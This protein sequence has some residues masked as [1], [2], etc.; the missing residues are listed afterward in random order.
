MEIHAIVS[1]GVAVLISSG[2]YLRFFI[3]SFNELK[4]RQLVANTPTS[5]IRSMAVGLVEIKGKAVPFKNI[6]ESAV[7]RSDCVYYEYL[8]E[9][10]SGGTNPKSNVPAHWTSVKNE[11][12]YKSPF[13]VEDDTGKVLVHPENA[14][15]Y[16]PI[17][18]KMQPFWKNKFQKS[19]VKDFYFRIFKNTDIAKHSGEGKAQS[20]LQTHPEVRT[21]LNAAMMWR[22]TE[23]I[24]RPG[25][26]VY[27]MGTA[28]MKKDSRGHDLN[29]DGLV[30]KMGEQEK[31]FIISAFSEEKILRMQ[32]KAFFVKIFFTSFLFI[33]SF[34]FLIL[35]VLFITQK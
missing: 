4:T 21:N 28:A 17:T 26:N 22:Y 8:V 25:D 15:M 34:V 3:T 14:I 19:I 6:Y 1:F 27:V 20:L 30:I 29:E 32:V 18:F 12:T 13:Y 5:K 24:I 2:L 11:A 35:Y 23:R 31:T 7:S 16:L 9:R 10:L 33:N